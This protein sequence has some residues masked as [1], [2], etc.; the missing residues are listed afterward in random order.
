M[1]TF[2]LNLHK[3]FFL[4]KNIFLCKKNFL[5]AWSRTCNNLIEVNSA[6]RPFLY[7]DIR[8]EK[9]NNINHIYQ[10]EMTLSITFVMAFLTSSFLYSP[11]CPGLLNLP[12]PLSLRGFPC[13]LWSKLFCWLVNTSRITWNNCTT[14]FPSVIIKFFTAPKILK[15]GAGAWQMNRRQNVQNPA[16]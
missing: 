12:S 9:Q 8:K 14:Y 4:E 5:C 2:F 6:I 7:V 11:E 10:Y 1:N 16:F 13:K 3:K 15:T